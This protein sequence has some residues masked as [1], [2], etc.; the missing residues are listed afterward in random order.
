[1]SGT[2][3][4][5]LCFL[6]LDP[7]GL[8]NAQTQTTVVDLPVNKRVL[9]SDPSGNTTTH[10]DQSPIPFRLG[11]GAMVYPRPTPNEVLRARRYLIGPQWYL[12]DLGENHRSTTLEGFEQSAP[13]PYSV[14][15]WPPFGGL[16]EMGTDPISAIYPS[17]AKGENDTDRTTR[18]FAD[19][20]FRDA[21]RGGPLQP[22]FLSLLGSQTVATHSQVPKSQ[23]PQ[24]RLLRAVDNYPNWITT[25]CT[26]LRDFYLQH[27]LPHKGTIGQRILAHPV[28]LF[29]GILLFV[30]LSI[31]TF[32]Y[33]GANND[34]NHRRPPQW[35]PNN[36]HNYSFRAYITDLMHWVMLTDLQPH[37]QAAAILMRLTGGARDLA[38]TITGDQILNGGMFEGQQLDP[39]SFIIAGLRARFGQLDEEARLA[40]MT[41]MLA[42]TRHRG[43]TINDVLSRYEL[44][45]GRAR[46]E[47][48]FVMSVEGAAL[49]LLRACGCN[50]AQFMTLLQPFDNH[51]PGTEAQ[52]R[53]LQERMRRIG[54]VMEHAP[55][56]VAQSLQG[57]RE[58]RAGAY[59]QVQRTAEQAPSMAAYFNS[60]GFA[61]NADWPSVEPDYS[62]GM[63]GGW[64]PDGTDA[65]PTYMTVDG[66]SNDDWDSGTDTDTSSDDGTEVIPNDDIRNM[67]EEQAAAHIYYGYKRGKRRWRRYTGK[68]VRYVRRQIKRAHY[69]AERGGLTNPQEHADCYYKG[70]KGKGKGGKGKRHRRVH[71]HGFK[72]SGPQSRG[73]VFLTRENM[74]TFLSGKGKLHRKGTSGQSFGRKGN[75]KDRN[76]NVMKCHGCNS[77]DHLIKDCPTGNSGAGSSGGPPTFHTQAPQP[78]PLMQQMDNPQ[79]QGYFTSEAPPVDPGPL[80][81]LLS[82]IQ[83]PVPDPPSLMVYSNTHSSNNSESGRGPNLLF[84]P[85]DPWLGRSL[86]QELTSGFVPADQWAN[87]QPTTGAYQGMAADDELARSQSSDAGAPSAPGPVAQI[88]VPPPQNP[89]SGAAAAF[90]QS[91]SGFL[92]PQQLQ[93]ILTRGRNQRQNIADAARLP[94]GQA[95]SEAQE[96]AARQ[97]MGSTFS[98]DVA[99]PPGVVP[100]PDRTPRTQRAIDQ[101]LSRIPAIF[102]GQARRPASTTDITT[103]FMQT[104]SVNPALG[105]QVVDDP[106]RFLP[107][108]PQNTVERQQVTL[109]AAAHETHAG[110]T[111]STTMQTTLMTINDYNTRRARTALGGDA[112]APSSGAVA[113][114]SGIPMPSTIPYPSPAP[115]ASSPGHPENQ[116]GPDPPIQFDRPASGSA[117]VPADFV[118]QVRMRDPGA[119]G[120]PSDI[121]SLTSGRPSLISGSPRS[122]RPQV[123]QEPA[124]MFEGE[125]TTCSVCLEDFNH[126][127][128]VCRLQCCHVFHATCFHTVAA[129]ADEP[130]CPNCRGYGRV[131]AFWPWI[132]HARITQYINGTDGPPR[133]S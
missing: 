9:S 12:D 11:S 43:E 74:E 1:M 123:A 33:A 6:A 59:M 49:Q 26:A 55:N 31:H 10:K 15:K 13:A 69:L 61:D 35:G 113:Y 115:A 128:R 40:A 93:D 52:F 16:M 131:I 5:L 78:P 37:Q 95:T 104:D 125:D 2:L 41:E 79:W 72:R 112:S 90:T 84:G 86:P 105:E 91:V 102:G 88:A 21:A 127:Q 132:D 58:A 126:G 39:V 87:F 63:W 22:G 42:F 47:G 111:R 25:S 80:D 99:G 32:M 116:T 36:E 20:R 94:D 96:A 23:L 81:E 130:R 64:N 29:Q 133:G 117:D 77:T 108:D 70:G 45:R 83:Q 60:P 17:F 48:N 65:Q 66:D 71:K 51:L 114:T 82:S 14:S 119:F 4:Y 85:N 7:L 124:H 34:F 68:R 30:W 8:T 121:S 67:T 92:S 3:G 57:N 120:P 89:S 97:G 75:P 28:I 18:V 50:S 46:D 109:P 19:T 76:G 106:W 129:T 101:A 103:A 118:E 54:H 24:L 100:T 27:F 122:P 44:V 73:H 107:Y 56:N 98:R 110:H 62:A 53:E 38:R